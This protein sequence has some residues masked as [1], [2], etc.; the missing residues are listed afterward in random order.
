MNIFWLA[1]KNL[2]RNRFWTVTTIII[3][4]VAMAAV[5]ASLTI[6]SGIG[7][8][9]QV[10]RERLGADLVVFPSGEEKALVG[11]LQSGNPA[12]FYMK[13]AMA[14]KVRSIDGVSKA[15]P[16][17][18]IMSLS[19]S[20]CSTNTPYRIVGFDPA[21]DFSVSPWLEKHNI[22]RLS[23]NA[24]IIGADVPSAKE[25]NI[26]LLSKDF[27]VAGA[28]ER[29][30]MGIDKTIYMNIDVARKLGVHSLY[31]KLKPDEISSILVKVDPAFDLQGV[32]NDIKNRVPGTAVMGS[33]QLNRSIK[34]IFDK[35]AFLVGMIFLVVIV[36]VCASIAGIYYAMSKSRGTEIGIL[37]SLGARKNDIVSLIVLESV[38]ST[39]I[40]GMIGIA[41][42][43]FLVADFNILLSKSLP[44]PFVL[45]FSAVLK[46]SL[47]CLILSVA[48]GFIGAIYPAWK[49]SKIDPFEA[50]RKGAQ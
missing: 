44:F 10:G 11:A 4:A 13:S 20:C 30:G 29:T 19:R 42:A 24:V 50:I 47:L 26:K 36:L 33:S 1:Q 31:L 12:L 6:I 45:S 25:E 14:E 46:N 16:E 17:L 41:I 5:F 9:L 23:D 39:L 38:F 43:A 35:M 28:L 48:L 15:S 2:A 34:V 7:D 21:N 40:G 22:G 3:S 27:K 8:S 32:A 49:T 37:R 18:Y